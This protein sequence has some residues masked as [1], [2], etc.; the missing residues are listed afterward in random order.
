MFLLMVDLTAVKRHWPQH[1]CPHGVRVALVGGEKQ[2]GHVY[3][4]RG[5]SAGAVDG[6]SSRMTIGIGGVIRSTFGLSKPETSMGTETLDDVAGAV[7]TSVGI[8]HVEIWVRMVS[9]CR[10]WSTS[11]SDRA[12]SCTGDARGG[13]ELIVD[14]GNTRA[15][16]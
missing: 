15:I 6:D 7:G 16:A 13:D 10:G 1:M 5:S 14:E 8:S 3:V 11:S 2:M 12:S 9:A 4:E